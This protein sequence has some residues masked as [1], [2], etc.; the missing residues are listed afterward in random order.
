MDTPELHGRALFLD[1]SLYTEIDAALGRAHGVSREKV[2]KYVWKADLLAQGQSF[3]DPK[4]HADIVFSSGLLPEYE[5]KVSRAVVF[6]E[7]GL[8]FKGHGHFDTVCVLCNKYC[9]VVRI[10]VMKKFLF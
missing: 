5:Y 3:R 4:S 1:R 6:N 10:L 7:E 8:A 2:M 9:H